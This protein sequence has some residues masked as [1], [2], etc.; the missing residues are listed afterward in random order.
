MRPENTMTIRQP[1]AL[2]SS[3]HGSISHRT[4]Q[5]GFNLIE[6][7][8]ALLVMSVMVAATVIEMHPVIQ[9]WRANTAMNQIMSQL[10]W[11]REASIAQRRNIQIQFNGINQIT[12]IRQEVPAGQTVLSSLALTGAM[13]FM[14]SP[15]MP[16]T[17]DRFG[18]AAPIEF[19]GVAGGPP[20]MQFQSDGTFIDG[21]GN[22][23]NGT[24]FL[25]MRNFP[26]AERAITVLGATGRVRTFRSTGQG[27]IR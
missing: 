21:N 16:D 17:P 9:Q 11:A 15:G 18:N 7:L 5:G 6:L 13:Q 24:V 4:R 26:A 23:I 22:P 2:Y 8:I 27:W 3:G 1:I 25:G 19:A 12:L 10:R 14:L 20:I